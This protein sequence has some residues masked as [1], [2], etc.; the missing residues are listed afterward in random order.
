MIFKSRL[1]YFL[2]VGLVALTTIVFSM[3]NENKDSGLD[4]KF[5]NE[6]FNF[7]ANDFRRLSNST[8]S[9]RIE[10]SRFIKSN[11]E[12]DLEFATRVIS[13]VYQNSFH[14]NTFKNYSGPHSKTAVYGLLTPEYAPCGLCSQINFWVN[15]ILR[16]NNVDSSLLGIEGHVVATL[17][18]SGTHVWIL[19]ADY[20]VAPF[21]VNLKSSTSMRRGALNAYAAMV[22]QSL[23]SRKVYYRIVSYY[24]NIN[25]DS[26]YDLTLLDEIYEDQKSFAIKAQYSHPANKNRARQFDSIQHLFIEI[27]AKELEVPFS[28]DLLNDWYI[29]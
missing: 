21:L 22:N 19:D 9:W 2:L 11:S 13:F 6:S 24:G 3:V 16:N 10:D 14:C 26:F 4:T 25:D 28:T 18:I 7:E 27:I 5:G 15:K 17:N 1:P 8:K 23:K 20:G 29:S 12:T